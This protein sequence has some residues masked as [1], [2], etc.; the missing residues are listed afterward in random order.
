MV[1]FLSYCCSA[2][3]VGEVALC[4]KDLNS[5]S[6]HPTMVSIWV[7]DSFE[8]K[9]MERELLAKLLVDLATSSDSTLNQVQLVKG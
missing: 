5:P 4:I 7:T 6:F 8:A 2:R 1:K 3:D 9:D